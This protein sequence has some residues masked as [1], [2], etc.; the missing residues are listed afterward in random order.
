MPLLR[1]SRAAID[2]PDSSS[3]FSAPIAP[4]PAANISAV[5]PSA[6]C[7]LAHIPCQLGRRE[8]Q[9]CAG[10]EAETVTHISYCRLAWGILQL[11]LIPRQKW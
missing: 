8:C 2:A 3:A 5:R 11:T 9:Q 7:E 6:S 4:L 10:L 1:R